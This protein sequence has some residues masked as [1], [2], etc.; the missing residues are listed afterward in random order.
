MK[1]RLLRKSAFGI[2]QRILFWVDIIC[3]PPVMKVG[4]EG[5]PC[6]GGF[7]IL[8]SAVRR[9]LNR[10]QDFCVSLQRRK[11]GEKFLCPLWKR[12][13]GSIMRRALYPLQSFLLCLKILGEKTGKLQLVMDY[14]WLQT[15][16]KTQKFLWAVMQLPAALVVVIAFAMPFQNVSSKVMQY[17]AILYTC[18]IIYLLIKGYRAMEPRMRTGLCWYVGMAAFSFAF[19]YIFPDAALSSA[20]NITMMDLTLFYTLQNPDADLIKELDIQK[21]RAEAATQAKSA[22]LSNMSH[23]IRTPIKQVEELKKA[24][25]NM[26]WDGIKGLVK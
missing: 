24:L 9:N 17:C 18:V 23:E 12:K 26:D 25:K 13:S 1:E 19:N 2:W 22:F 7:F 21:N 20:L 15:H 3:S 8:S 5:F 6:P 10:M 4:R 16:E 14:L 11:E